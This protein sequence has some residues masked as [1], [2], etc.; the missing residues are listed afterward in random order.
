[1]SLLN[2][3]DPQFNSDGS[4]Y[5]PKKF[6]DL[7]QERYLIS[8]YCHTSYN[9]LGEISPLERSYLVEFIEEEIKKQKE[10]LEKARNKKQR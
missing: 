10:E 9:E 6:K 2:F 1:M 8:K 3:L 4:L 7:V 5:A